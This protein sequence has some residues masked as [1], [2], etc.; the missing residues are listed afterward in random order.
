MASLTIKLDLPESLHPVLESPDGMVLVIPGTSA[1]VKAFGDSLRFGLA[2]ARSHAKTLHTMRT[3]FL[4]QGE[5]SAKLVAALDLLIKEA[6]EA[7]WLL[8][9]ACGF[10][11][12]AI[13]TSSLERKEN[14]Q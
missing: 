11:N 9:M 3:G 8:L 13:P 2:F 14:L 12:R 10:I 4:A 1:E 7:E 5:V 6:G